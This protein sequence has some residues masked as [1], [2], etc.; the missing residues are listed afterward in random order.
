M[1]EIAIRAAK[2]SDLADFYRVALLTG[3]SGSDATGMHLNDE[4]L[5]EVFVGPYVKL[6]LTSCFALVNGLD[7]IGYGLCVPDTKSFEAIS[8]KNWWPQ[9]QE[10]YQP[11]KAQ[12]ES[13]W[14]LS[15]IFNPE[16]SP[17]ELLEEYP[18][19][20]HIDLLPEAQ[21]K[22]WGRK[23]MQQMERTLIGLGASGFHLRVSPYNRRA[24]DFYQALNYQVLLEKPNEIVVGKRLQ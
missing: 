4:M 11:Y 15:E 16:P 21:G 6:S 2:S 13:N 22:G 17:L 20:G 3:D 23:I 9:L 19:H 12:I 18:A 10:K 1:G 14:L 8:A 5:G 7:V 24:L